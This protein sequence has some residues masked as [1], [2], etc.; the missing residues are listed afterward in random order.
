[1]TAYMN[2]YTGDV[3]QITDE[4]V[5]ANW[6]LGLTRAAGKLIAGRAAPAD[7]TGSFGIAIAGSNR[8]HIQGNL[9]VEVNCSLVEVYDVK[10]EGGEEYNFDSFGGSSTDVMTLT[11]NATCACGRIVRHPVQMNMTVSEIIY[12]LMNAE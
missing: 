7:S 1:M 3:L 8:E 4:E 2:D 5:A 12:G 9:G 11:A 6:R 10:E